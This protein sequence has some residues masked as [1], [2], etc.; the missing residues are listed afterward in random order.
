MI[1][2]DVFPVVACMR[3]LLFWVFNVPMME[4]DVKQVIK[5]IGVAKN[6]FKNV[7]KILKTKEVNSSLNC[8]FF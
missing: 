4:M 6:I 7:K 3:R 1:E 2:F 5:S 8:T